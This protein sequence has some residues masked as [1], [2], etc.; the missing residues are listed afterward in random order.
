MDSHGCPGKGVMM[1]MMR[2]RMRRMTTMMITL[3]IEKYSWGYHYLLW[4]KGNVMLVNL[5]IRRLCR[6]NSISLHFP[7]W[8][9]MKSIFS[10]LSVATSLSWIIYQARKVSYLTIEHHFRR[11]F[12]VWKSFFTWYHVEYLIGQCW[13]FQ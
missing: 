12:W 13:L 5:K 11:M 10:V 6:P 4:T 7:M 9:E 3:F 1:M 2:W 8:Y